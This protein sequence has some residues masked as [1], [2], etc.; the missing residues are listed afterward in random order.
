MQSN[1]LLLSVV[2]MHASFLLYLYYLYVLLIRT[3]RFSAC[4]FLIWGAASLPLPDLE[5]GNLGAA[6][7]PLLQGE[8]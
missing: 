3:V 1:N 5:S 2:F 8:R 7:L 6:T 4:R